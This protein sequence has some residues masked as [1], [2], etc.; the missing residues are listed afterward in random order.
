MKRLVIIL[1]FIAPFITR[2]TNYTSTANGNWSVSTTWS[3][4]GVPGSGD[5]VT[6]ANTVTL[7][8]SE[9]VNNITINSGHTLTVSTTSIL[10][11]FG[12]F[13]NSGTFTYATGTVIMAGSST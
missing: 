11:V 13:T 5:N 1:L 10:T 7:N 12:N 3:P 4:S 8:A 6:I 2:A 9:S